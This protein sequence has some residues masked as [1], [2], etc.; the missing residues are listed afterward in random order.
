MKKYIILFMMSIM[1]SPLAYG[2]VEKAKPEWAVNPVHF[3]GKRS[4]VITIS[5]YGRSKE[6][7][8]VR[9]FKVLEA[10]GRKLDE[11]YRIIDEYWEY[12]SDLAY[13]YFLVQIPH[14]MKCSDWE[15]VELNTTR[16]PFSGRCF[17]PGMAQIYKGSKVKGGLII[18]AEALGVAGIVTSFSMMASYDRL[19]LE[20]KK[21]ASVY[22]DQADLWQN[23]GWGSIAFTAAIYIY[24]VIDGAVAPGKRHIQI[25]SKSFNYAIAPMAT[26]RGDVGFAAQFTF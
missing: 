12:T 16:Y 2:Q 1:L 21:H 10:E 26:P 22:A 9:A 13:G 15:Y 4:K 20:D 23:I 25:G 8:K 11:G 7:T 24:N 3:E 14:E 17:V 18:G 19:V 5:E 6:S